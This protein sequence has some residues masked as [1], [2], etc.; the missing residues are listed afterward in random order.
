MNFI[1]KPDSTSICHIQ[2]QNCTHKREIVSTQ[3]TWCNSK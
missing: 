2:D 1:E 3:W